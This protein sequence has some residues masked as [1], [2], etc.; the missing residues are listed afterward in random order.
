[1]NTAIQDIV[2]DAAAPAVL[3]P[4][5]EVKNCSNCSNEL[6]VNGNGRRTSFGLNLCDDCL[7]S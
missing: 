2:I 1:M 3:C 6:H 5:I 4:I 7:Y